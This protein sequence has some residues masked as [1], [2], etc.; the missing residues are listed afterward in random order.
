MSFQL[1]PCVFQM[2]CLCSFLFLFLHVIYHFLWLILRFFITSFQQFDY[3]VPGHVFFFC[4]CAHVCLF[5]IYLDLWVYSQFQRN[6]DHYFFKYFLFTP[7]EIPIPHIL[8]H[9]RLFHRSLR[10]GSFVG[11]IMVFWWC[12]FGPWFTLESFYIP[13]SKFIDHFFCGV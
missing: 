5:L 7:L 4:V 1:V 9:L 11:F 8:D 2:R 12:F 10:L 3:A 6:F 13:V